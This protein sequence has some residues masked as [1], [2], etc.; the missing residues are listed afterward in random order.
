MLEILSC[1][2]GLRSVLLRLRWT[3]NGTRRG[4]IHPVERHEGEVTREVGVHD[5]QKFVRESRGSK[6]ISNRI[7][8]IVDDDIRDP[9][10]GLKETVRRREYD[11][12]SIVLGRPDA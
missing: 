3:R 7:I 12:W 9:I 1:R 2:R 8:V 11:N 4:N 5:T 10:W 6:N